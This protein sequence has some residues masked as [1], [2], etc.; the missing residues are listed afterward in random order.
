MNKKYDKKMHGDDYAKKMSG[1]NDLAKQ[2]RLKSLMRQDKENI[3]YDIGRV[4][5]K[6]DKAV[7][8]YGYP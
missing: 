3:A 5:A 2:E 1:G 6:T 4:K 8:K 7:K